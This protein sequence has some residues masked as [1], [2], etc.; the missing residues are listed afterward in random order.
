MREIETAIDEIYTENE[1]LAASIEANLPEG[2]LSEMY[3]E[4]Q[5]RLNGFVTVF[6]EAIVA[7]AQGNKDRAV[8]IINVK[9][10]KEA[11]E[12]TGYLNEL[13]QASQQEMAVKVASQR[14]TYNIAVMESVV[15]SVL[16]A[17]VWVV[18][19]LVIMKMIV[20]PP[21]LC[22]TKVL[23]VIT[24]LQQY[25]G[26]LTIR[27]PIK[28]EDEIRQLADS[29]KETANNIQAVNAMVT[30]AVKELVK[31]SNELASYIN[32]RVLPDYESFVDSGKQYNADA[33]HVNEVV[34]RFNTMAG[35]LNELIQNI[36]E[37]ISG[38]SIA[39]DESANGASATATNTS[40]LVKE[41]GHISEEMESNH[42]VAA[43][44]NKYV[45]IFKHL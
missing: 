22:N 19:L 20:R 11:D 7:S 38:I 32:E 35:D 24:S 27:I 10:A 42:N 12:L 23:E 1:A 25:R 16:A 30:A 18:V 33:V 8:A 2:P 45:A 28:G 17:L 43:E 37:A 6:T 39:V 21:E 40:E 15:V 5:N 9:V 34:D 29:S 26:D 14:A 4:Y 41:M 3:A 44:L 13:I 31:S 36:T